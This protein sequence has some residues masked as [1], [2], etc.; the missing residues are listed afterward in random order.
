[1]GAGEVCL[2]YHDDHQHKEVRWGRERCV[3]FTMTTTN[4][5]R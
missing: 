2:V 5:R 4:T 1:M 3:L